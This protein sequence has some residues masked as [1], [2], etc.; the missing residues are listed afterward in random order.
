MN[1]EPDN[2]PTLDP[3]TAKP[4]L[5]GLAVHDADDLLTGHVFGLLCEAETGLI[6]FLDIELDGKGRHVLVPVGH[7]R[8]ES[9]ALGP[10]IRLRAASLDDLERVPAYAADGSWPNPEAAREMLNV[11]GRF[12]RGD[13]YYAHPAYD[14]RGLYAGEHPIVKEGAKSDRAEPCLESLNESSDF[15]IA[16]GEPDVRGWTLVDHTGTAAAEV[17]DIIIDTAAL[18]VR[19]LVVS[20]SDGQKTL[21]PIGYVE[22]VAKSKRVIVPGLSA[23]DLLTFPTFESLPLSR[24]QEDRSREHIER[25][26]DARNPFLRVDFSPR[27]VVA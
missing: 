16:E 21:V 17:A 11:H 15:R 7:A 18:K 1:P 2:D 25:A 9:S 26:L 19:Y 22:V 10:R 13:K 4:D 20:R 14:H 3:L 8:V 23:E 27:T 24:E 12:F 5:A 6:R